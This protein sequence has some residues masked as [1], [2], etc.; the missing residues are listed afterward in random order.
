MSSFLWPAAFCSSN[1]P[2]CLVPT[3]KPNYLS[4]QGAVRLKPNYLRL[5]GQGVVRL[6]A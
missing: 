2:F 3:L 4:G 5:R 1:P 6:V